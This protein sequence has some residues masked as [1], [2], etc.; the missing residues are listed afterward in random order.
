MR[1]ERLARRPLAREGTHLRGVSSRR[2]GLLG[3]FLTLLGVK[4]SLKKRLKLTS[5]I[6]L[7][8]FPSFCAKSSC[9]FGSD[10]GFMPM[11]I[12]LRN[13]IAALVDAA[14]GLELAIRGL[15]ALRTHSKVGDA[16][17]GARSKTK[18]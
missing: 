7:W 13:E 17:Y 18:P 6:A 15:R 5:S 4:N 2:S 10:P 9:V 3:F 12:K 8:T 14:H 11:G 1:R 16:Y